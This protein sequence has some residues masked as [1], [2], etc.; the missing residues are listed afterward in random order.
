MKMEYLAMEDIKKIIAEGVRLAYLKKHEEAISYFDKVLA[1]DG[2]N[3]DVLLNK[4]LELMILK[5]YQEAIQTC[6]KILELDSQHYGA[7]SNKG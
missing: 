7:L 1:I 3:K 2:K 4:S 6:D 5:R